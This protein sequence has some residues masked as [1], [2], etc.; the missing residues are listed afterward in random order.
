MQDVIVDQPDAVQTED[1]DAR[2]RSADPDR[3][4]DVGRSL[5]QSDPPVT[6][7]RHVTAGDRPPNGV[8]VDPS[9]TQRNGGGDTAEG[10]QDIERMRHALEDRRRLLAA[11]SRAE[12]CGE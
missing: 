7:A 3:R 6:D 12:I 9:V 4:G 1:G 2:Q 11:D 10:I 5:R 8:G